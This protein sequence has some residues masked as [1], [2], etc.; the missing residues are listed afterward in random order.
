MFAP[1][2]SRFPKQSKF[3]DI[4]GRPLLGKPFFDVLPNG[5]QLQ[6]IPHDEEFADQVVAAGVDEKMVC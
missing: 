5:R 2:W 1:F 4:Y 3:E 6:A